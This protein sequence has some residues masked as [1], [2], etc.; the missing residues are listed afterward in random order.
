MGNARKSCNRNRVGVR[1]LLSEPETAEANRSIIRR[2]PYEVNSYVTFDSPEALTN[3][4]ARRSGGSVHLEWKCAARP[5][6][7]GPDIACRQLD[8]VLAGSCAGLRQGKGDL[9]G[10]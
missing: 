4:P 3:A 1:H 8:L 7:K 10:C 9:T 6:D 2:K 5:R